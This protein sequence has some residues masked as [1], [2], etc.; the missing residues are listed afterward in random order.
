MQGTRECSQSS[1]NIQI[2]C[3]HGCIYCYAHRMNQRFPKV[4]IPDWTQPVIRAA[5]V[6]KAW[7]KHDGIIM[8]PTTHDIT[9]ANFDAC[10]QVLAKMLHAE[11]RVLLVSKPTFECIEA[12]LPLLISF[13]AQMECRFTIGTTDNFMLRLFEPSAQGIEERLACL[14]M[15]HRHQIAASVSGEPCLGGI[16]ETREL[17]A[18]C[19]P[20]ITQGI[21]IGTLNGGIQTDDALTREI[22][23]KIRHEQQDKSAW[24]DAFDGDPVVRWKE[25]M[26]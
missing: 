22:A 24:H 26:K 17:I 1:Y 10:Q 9:P 11:N 13:R 3:E 7:T 14:R 6:Q 20:Y 12:I 19:R 18:A 2:G 15:L 5:A 25:T 4:R 21:W 23:A 16:P 8:F